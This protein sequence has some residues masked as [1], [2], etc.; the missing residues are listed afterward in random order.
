MHG[1]LK[2]AMAA[3]VV[4]AVSVSGCSSQSHPPTTSITV[5]ASSAMIK[6][7]TSIGKQFEAEN[8]GTSVE[9]IFASSS[10]LSAELADGN[11]ADVSCRVTTRT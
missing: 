11:D 8:P 3:G 1:R 5:F 7:L 2:R 10:D 6:S 9:F 4:L